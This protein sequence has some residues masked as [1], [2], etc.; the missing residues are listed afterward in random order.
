MTPEITPV[1]HET[2]NHLLEEDSSTL[3]VVPAA[4]AGHYTHGSRQ[5]DL[6]FD[7]INPFPAFANPVDPAR[8]LVGIYAERG[9]TL[10]ALDHLA[11]RDCPHPMCGNVFDRRLRELTQIPADASLF[12]AYDVQTTWTPSPLPYLIHIDDYQA[13]ERKGGTGTLAG[14]T[15]LSCGWDNA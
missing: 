6:S 5:A 12:A 4:L 1:H 14:H 3:G 15:E 13:A 8:L 9:L 11:H 2:L 10:V 7:W